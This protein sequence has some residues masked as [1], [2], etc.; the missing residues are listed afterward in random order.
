M[1]SIR[2]KT[3]IVGVAYSKVAR[4][5]DV[6]V[7]ALAVEACKKAIDDAGLKVSDIDGLSV[8]PNPSRLEAGTVDGVDFVGVNYIARVLHLKQ[9]RWY[10]SQVQ[11]TLTASL[12]EAVNAV[13][14][15]ACDYA[16]VWRA[17]Y[18]PPG[19]FGTYTARRSPGESQFTAPYGLANAIMMF[20]MPYSRYMAKYGAKREHLATFIVNN[21]KNGAMNPEGVFYKQ[22]LTFQDYMECRMIADP[23]CI[24]DCDMAVDGCGA[25]VIT[26]ADRARH[27]K[28]KPAYVTGYSFSG[29]QLRP[30][31][32]LVWE[33]FQERANH[34]ARVLWEN[35]GLSAKDIDQPNLYDGFSWFIYPWL[36]ALGFCKEGEAFEF[37]QGGRI[38]LGGEL[39]MN[40]SGGALAMGRLHGSPQVIEAVRQLQ[41]RCGPRQVKDAK[42]T[43]A[44][45]GSPLH[46]SGAMV[47]SAEP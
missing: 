33:D 14:V 23:M 2:N 27:L 25:M 15:G 18:S 6:S 12:A 28:Q 30:A 19:A 21:R 13:A 43:L 4:H 42:V 46:G 24:F 29:M 17:M 32:V 35:T 7:G 39:P 44:H 8:Y 45:V 34:I 5:A 20:S 11:G 16:L 9:A 10:N 41:G 37:I 47:F 26:T 38:E 1:F 40:T 22:P 36:E 31:L 3:A